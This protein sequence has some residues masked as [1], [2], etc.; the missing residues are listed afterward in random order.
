[1]PPTPCLRTK[2]HPTN[3]T[4]FY[5]D[6]EQKQI[7]G[8]SLAQPSRTGSNLQRWRPQ[9]PSIIH[10]GF[11]TLLKDIHIWG[12]NSYLPNSASCQPNNLQQQ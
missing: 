8:D 4:L 3:Y 6:V 5:R 7:Q 2:W 1:M 11:A 10:T 12:I 9:V